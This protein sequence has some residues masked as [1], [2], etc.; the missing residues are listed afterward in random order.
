[1][2]TI[3]KIFIVLFLNCFCLSF[4]QG[5]KKRNSKIVF[6]DLKSKAVKEYTIDKDTMK[7]RF[8]IYVK[9]YESKEERDKATEV[10]KD[11]V[12]NIRTSGINPSEVR[13]PTFSIGFYSWGGKP[14]KL[15]S[16]KGI[17]FITIKQFQDSIYFVK[18]PSYIIHQLKDGTYLKW[19]TYT[20]EVVD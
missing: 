4:S 9:K 1:M 3:K 8:S 19:K 17:K 12:K 11:M 14:E 16:L 6:L 13:L 15:K 10:Y 18:D 7:A 2:S 20:M 5:E